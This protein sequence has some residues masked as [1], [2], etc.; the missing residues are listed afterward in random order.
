MLH[1][2]AQFSLIAFLSILSGSIIHLATDVDRDYGLNKLFEIRGVRVPPED[3]VI[4][5]MDEASEFFF[6]ETHS[7]ITQEQLIDWRPFHAKLINE[8]QKQ[9]AKLI[10]FDLQFIQSFP[11]QDQI[12][13][14]AMQHAGNVLLSECIQK[15]TLS[16]DKNI[17]AGRD[18]C[19][20]RY[21]VPFI[22]KEGETDQVDALMIG[23]R[24]IAPTH[25]IADAAL[26]RAPFYL[27]DYVQHSSIQEA[28]LFFDALAENPSLPLVAWINHL[29]KNGLLLNII[30]QNQAAS[31]WLAEQRASCKSNPHQ[32]ALRE[33]MNSS[34]KIKLEQLICDSDTRYLNY[35][36]P[37]KSFRTL[38]YKTVYNGQADDLQGKIIFI[39]KLNRLF[40]QGKVDFFPTPF[41]NDQTGR[42]SGVEILATQFSNLLDDRFI[43]SPFPPILI[44]VCFGFVTSLQLVIFRRSIGLSSSFVTFCIYAGFSIYLFNNGIWLP[45][46]IP[47]WQL[48]TSYVIY[49]FLQISGLLKERKFIYNFIKKIFPQWADS[50]P[51]LPQL[52]NTQEE[53]IERQN[54]QSIC[55]ATDIQGYTKTAQRLEK[56][57]ELRQ[58]LKSYYQM[59]GQPIAG[60]KGY[61]ANIQGDAMMAIWIDQPPATQRYAA[62]IAALEIQKEVNKFNE[63][64]S[65]SALPTRIGINAGSINLMCIKSAGSLFYNPFGDTLNTASRI[66]GVNKYLKTRILA[67]GLIVTDLSN[68]MSRSVGRFH[69]VGKDEPIEL[70][71]IIGIGKLL[72]HPNYPL[73]KNFSEGLQLFQKGQWK[74]AIIIFQSILDQYG[75]DGPTEFYLA[76]AQRHQQN[77]PA[78][79]NGA[80]VLEGK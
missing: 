5:A 76:N 28:W 56:S 50:I 63:T 68:I 13:A 17:F 59:L 45:I 33:T 30:P 48:L 80:L 6:S 31:A 14:A 19:S 54:V 74:N 73:Y 37:P 72:T 77:E 75:N 78:N 36:G 20:N 3:V 2:L 44:I 62:C 11:E 71:E 47:F 4:V 12:M 61:I 18:D 69:L 52:W 32:F 26:D 67:S 27:P 43:A 16:N 42:M 1:K 58:L 60:N 55:L 10:I 39:G 21:R 9:S 49:F 64:S 46:V 23:L 79:W 41:T 57:G 70:F 24:K 22:N 66:E 51:Q 40:A 35:Y 8:L 25:V 29:R 7:N 53:R 34:L 38:S 15:I 65:I